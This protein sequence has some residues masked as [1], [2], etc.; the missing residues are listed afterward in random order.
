MTSSVQHLSDNQGTD[1][2]QKQAHHEIQQQAL[3]ESNGQIGVGTPTDYPMHHGHREAGPAV[4]QFVYPFHDPYYG[5]IFAAYSAQT[6]IHPPLMGMQHPG[7]PL[8]TDEEPVFVNAKQYHGILRRRQSRAKAESENK[9]IKGRKPYLH[10]SR[11][12]H[13]LKRARGS[14]GRF[15]NTKLEENENNLNSQSHQ[16]KQ[17]EVSAIFA[18]EKREASDGK[19][20]S[21]CAEAKCCKI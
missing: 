15:V 19:A 5:G 6:A 1:E 21:P 10:E 9:L 3:L 18:Q 7:L 8:P 16:Q 17:N 12:R 14:G 11:H 2:Q 13:A 4:G 20:G